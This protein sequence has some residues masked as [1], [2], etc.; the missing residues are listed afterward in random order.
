[1]VKL[2]PHLLHLVELNMGENHIVSTAGNVYGD[3]CESLNEYI[4]TKVPINNKSPP[5]FYEKYMKPL[6][7]SNCD[8]GKFKL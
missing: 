8:G 2:R 3:I 5:V 4:T 7:Q 1:M 6:I